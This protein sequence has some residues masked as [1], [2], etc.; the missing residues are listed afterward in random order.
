VF[1]ELRHG[2]APSVTNIA[3]KPRYLRAG[4]LKA[5]L[6]DYGLRELSVYVVYP[7]RRHLSPKVR[8]FV[9]FVQSVFRPRLRRR[10]T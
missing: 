7:E 3:G 5:V 10:W 2:V 4:R 6:T 9:D 8:A 1:A